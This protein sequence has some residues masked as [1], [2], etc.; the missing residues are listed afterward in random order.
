MNIKQRLKSRNFNLA[1]KTIQMT[2]CPYISSSP[3]Y[4]N[5]Y[6]EAEKKVLRSYESLD[7][8][9]PDSAIYRDWLREQQKEQGGGQP[10][11]LVRSVFMRIFFFIFV[12]TVQNISSFIG[13]VDGV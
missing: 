7:Y 10:G 12:S 1:L 9:P 11:D 4:S 8:L 3:P 13:D 6:T 5:R 2:R